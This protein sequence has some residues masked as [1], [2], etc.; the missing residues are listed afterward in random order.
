MLTEQPNII[1]IE[2]VKMEKRVLNVFLLPKLSMNNIETRTPR[3]SARV[4]QTNVA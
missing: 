3:N 4:V 2:E 1:I